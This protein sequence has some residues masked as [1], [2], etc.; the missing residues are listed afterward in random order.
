MPRVTFDAAAVAKLEKLRAVELG[1]DYIVHVRRLKGS[2]LFELEAA[3]AAPVSE[4]AFRLL[5]ILLCDAKAKP[6]YGAWSAQA[7]KELAEWPAGYIA[8]ALTEGLSLNGL[9]ADDDPN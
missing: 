3:Q 5:A 2:K 6:T 4:Q 1:E 7:G 8:K 9:E